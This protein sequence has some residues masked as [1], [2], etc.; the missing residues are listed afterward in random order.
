MVWF[1]IK[2]KWREHRYSFLTSDISLSGGIKTV[3]ASRFAREMYHF[4]LEDQERMK[5]FE[6]G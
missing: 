5:L 3:V 2:E 4:C 1:D 6:L